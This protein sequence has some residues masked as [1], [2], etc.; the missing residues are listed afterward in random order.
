MRSRIGCQIAPTALMHT[1]DRF[2]SGHQLA[3]QVDSA[4]Q[5]Q[6]FRSQHYSVVA[7]SHNS[8]SQAIP[9]N[10]CMWQPSI[11]TLHSRLSI[12]SLLTP[13]LS[14]L[15]K[16]ICVPPSAASTPRSREKLMT[17]RALEGTVSRQP[18]SVPPVIP[19]P[20]AQQVLSSYPVN[21]SPA[22]SHMQCCPLPA[23]ML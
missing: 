16:K 4:L 15:A 7:L 17:P 14:H 9:E 22:Q 23:Q 3:A 2:W 12:T 13:A 11:A 6:G 21:G 5:R 20:P 1:C 18:A 19:P 10:A 8:W